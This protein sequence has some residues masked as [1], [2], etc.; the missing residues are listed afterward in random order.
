[1]NEVVLDASMAMELPFTKL[2]CYLG[3]KG[4]H[5]TSGAK[6]NRRKGQDRHPRGNA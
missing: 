1:M 6:S 5:G 3:L 4:K 2:K